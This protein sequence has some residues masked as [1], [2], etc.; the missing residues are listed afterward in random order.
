ML[1]NSSTSDCLLRP[2]LNTPA[3]KSARHVLYH[4]GGFW[5]SSEA[6]ARARSLSPVGIPVQPTNSPVA[7]VPAYA[8]TSAEFSLDDVIR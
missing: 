3:E 5:R 7:Y 2:V 8:L 4:L 1:L 6:G